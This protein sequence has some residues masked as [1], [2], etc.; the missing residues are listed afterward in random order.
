[1]LRVL[2][3]LECTDKDRC[4]YIRRIFRHSNIVLFPLSMPLLVLPTTFPPQRGNQDAF[5]FFTSVSSPPLGG[6]AV[7]RGGSS[8][9]NNSLLGI[10]LRFRVSW[11]LATGHWI[12]SSPLVTLTGLTRFSGCSRFSGFSN[13]LITTGVNIR[14]AFSSIPTLSYSRLACP[15]WYFVPPFPPKGEPRRLSLFSLASVSPFGG[16]CRRQRGHL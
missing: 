10:W 14:A 3:F 6:D 9:E 4:Q 1:M 2:R 16:R 7:G 15:F 5:R 8:S 12:L 11:P 13:V